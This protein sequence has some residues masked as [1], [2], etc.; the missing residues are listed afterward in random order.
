MNT[1]NNNLAFVNP[2]VPILRRRL[3]DPVLT[4][5]KFLTPGSEFNFLADRDSEIIWGRDGND[6]LLGFDPA[7]N[8][9][10]QTQIDIFLGDSEDLV[11]AAFG[12]PNLLA[13]IA[14]VAQVF[15]GTD[16]ESATNIVELISR[17][18]SDSVIVGERD[19]QDTYILG[20]W[21]QPYYLGG[22]GLGLNQFAVLADFNSRQD[23]IELHGIPEDYQL[24]ESAAGTG[25]FWQHETG[26]DLVAVLPMVT[27]LSLE[28]DY[29]KF[30][31]DTP[32]AGP[33]VEEAQ[34]IGTAGIDFVFNSTVD[35]D[36]NLYI[37]GGTSGSLGGP[38]TGPRDAWVTK[39]DSNGNQQWIQQF[40]TDNSENVW[41]LANDGDN[42]YVVGNTSGDLA[43][44]NK[45]GVDE[46]V[47]LSKFDSDG[48]QLW[49]RQFGSSTFDQSF[50]V[51]TDSEGNIYQSGYTIG[52]VGGSNHNAR[53]IQPSTDSWLTKFD[54]DGNQLWTRQFG[55][56]FND[57][58]Y[59]LAIDKDDNVFLGGWTLGDLGGTNAG[60]YDTWITKY[61]G[62]GNQL[63]VE[64][65]GT[66]DYEFLWGLDTDN[67][68]NV[69]ASGWTLGDLGGANAGSY[70]TWVAKYDSD[71]NQ[72]WIEQFGTSGDDGTFLDSLE[73]DSNNNIFL[74]GYTD[75]DL[76]GENA[77]S[78]DVWVA[79]YDSNGNQQWI[80]QFG[81]PDYDYAGSISTDD[82]GN[83][84]VT[85]VTEG[86]LG[87]SNAGSYDPWVVKLDA[88][89]GSL[90][91]FS[92]DVLSSLGVD[93]MLL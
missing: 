27:G 64:Q 6:R 38:N 82:F 16:T 33:V 70:D 26:S 39:F 74:A 58:T 54:S 51:A 57:D 78:Y 30:I 86:S 18:F 71:G 32:P 44:I 8:N 59:G 1:D 63:W 80:E 47:Y 28:D 22:S 72:Q 68:G 83:L 92:G 77:G 60:V 87:A 4:Y 62:D 7:A 53:D 31:G 9:Q 84:Y 14:G 19:W 67:E 41:A 50:A 85:G 56:V 3:A 25:I 11:A 75:S 73:V 46:D 20:D 55:T 29:F 36:G 24:I 66:P 65:F 42:I 91:N 23:I 2:I 17:E 49:T 79:K 34:Q 13:L 93:E 37:G 48:N 15:F 69:Y 40:G 61:D 90:Q 45:T 89:S 52:D 81:T 35:P 88:E 12:T 43:G 21:Q 5:L 76:G 10:D